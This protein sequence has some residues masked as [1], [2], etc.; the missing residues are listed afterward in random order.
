M[1]MSSVVPV[2]GEEQHLGQIRRNRTSTLCRVC[3]RRGGKFSYMTCQAR[4][5]C[6]V[7]LKRWLCGD[8]FTPWTLT[9]HGTPPLIPRGRCWPHCWPWRRSH[10]RGPPAWTCC[11]PSMLASK[12]RVD[13]WGSPERP[14]T[15]L[16]G[17]YTTL[18]TLA[19]MSRIAPHTEEGSL[20]FGY[21]QWCPLWCVW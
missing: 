10:P 14:S 4:Q 13:S 9:T 6:D 18:D 12:C 8:R 3:Q 7:C 15:S 17:R 11:W 1:W 2:R 5:S 19:H 21:F 20:D 16:K